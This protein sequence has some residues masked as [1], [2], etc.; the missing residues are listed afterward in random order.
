VPDLSTSNVTLTGSFVYELLNST[1]SLNVLGPIP[2][3]AGVAV[4]VSF[5][6]PSGQ[7]SLV[8]ATP[9]SPDLYF[10]S[11]LTNMTGVWNV[12][13]LVELPIVNASVVQVNQTSFTVLPRRT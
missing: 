7:L 12:T 2:L 10:A 8:P 1:V 9:L 11:L 3:P 5:V 13:A 6:S 4:N